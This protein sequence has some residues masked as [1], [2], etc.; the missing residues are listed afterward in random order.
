MAPLAS[1]DTSEPVLR[2]QCVSVLLAQHRQ[3]VSVGST[4]VLEENIQPNASVRFDLRIDSVPFTRYWL[5]AQAER[6][7]Q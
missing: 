3:I 6:D 7:W 1:I 2:P 4:F 5:Y